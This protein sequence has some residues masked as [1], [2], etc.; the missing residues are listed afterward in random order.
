MNK[1]IYETKINY[2]N[3]D[4]ISKNIIFLLSLDSRIS[5]SELAK[6]LKIT[7]KMAETR[8][9]NLYKN[10]IIN[11]LLIYNYR[12]LV[13]S[14][15]LIKLLKFNKKVIN[16]LLKVDNLVKLKETLGQYDLALLFIT[17]NREELNLALTKISSALH[18]QIQNMD[19][20]IH[21]YEDTLGYKSFC[22]NPELLKEYNL[23]EPDQDY[24]LSK[25][26][27]VLIKNLISDPVQPY[28][29]I[30]S[31]TGWTYTKIRS[32]MSDLSKKNIIRFSVD[33]D[34]KLMGLEYHNI[35][36]KI[37]LGMYKQ[38]EANIQKEARIHWMKKGIGTWDYILSVCAES[39]SEF[40]QVTREIR[41]QNEDIIL[42]LS[43]LISNVHMTRKN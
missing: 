39:I 20:M 42:D 13:K 21:E 31:S 1:K 5:V 7:R 4:I 35:L 8:M 32:M 10:R 26:D 29:N 11:P 9:N 30:V 25:D 17:E 14:T 3:I 19:V 12:G 36:V 43:T 37:D 16:S 15:I 40:I 27:M 2:Q 34:Y 22:D 23:L 41:E 6:K 38:F 33:P 24:I 28:K 18:G